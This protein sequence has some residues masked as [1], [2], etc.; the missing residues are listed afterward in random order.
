MTSLAPR[1]LLGGGKRLWRAVINDYQL[2]PPERELLAEACRTVDLL[3]ILRAEVE[4]TGPLLDASGGVRV[5]PAV[6]ELRQQRLVL[7]RLVAA[8]GLPKGLAEDAEDG[9]V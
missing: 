8:L 5:H 2:D 3:A 1:G 4:E 6:A 7:A 9:G